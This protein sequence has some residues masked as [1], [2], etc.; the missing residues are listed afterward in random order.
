MHEETGYDI[1]SG[2][3][4]DRALCAQ[5]GQDNVAQLFIVTN[6]PLDYP[7]RP[8]T[9]NEIRKI[10]WYRTQKFIKYLA[11]NPTCV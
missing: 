5:L 3:Q 4:E 6:V 10:Q 9:R 8:Q 2:S 7:F 11:Y 1:T